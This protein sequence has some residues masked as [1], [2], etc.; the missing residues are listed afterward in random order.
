MPSISS[1]DKLPSDVLERLQELLRDRRCT[2]LDITASINA[3]LEERGEDQ[4]V[5]KSAINR[6]HVRMAEV[7]DKLRQSREVAAM[8]IGKLGAAPQGQVGNLIN[9][10]LR[11]LAFDV[12]LKLQ[13]TDLTAEEMPGV[14][15]MLKEL[16]LSVLRLEQAAGENVKREQE[17]KKQAAEELAAKVA[18]EPGGGPITP[19]RLRQIIRESYGV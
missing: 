6:Y 19:E 12:S 16:S 15:G 18:D 13:N 7:G 4:R 11:T 14:I 2:Q 1:V 3:L 9:E 8:W 10:I 17:I 5:S